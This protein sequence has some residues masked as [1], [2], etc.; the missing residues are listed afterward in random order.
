MWKGIGAILILLGVA[1]CLHRWYLQQKEKQER[2]EELIQ[3]V[4]KSIHVMETEKMK[5]IDWFL[6]Y[7]NKRDFLLNETLSEIAKR[8]QTNTYASGH[9]VWEDVFFEKWQKLGFEEDVLQCLIQLGSGFFGKSR[10]E[11]IGI[12]QRG[13]KELEALQKK[14]KEKDAQER[15]VW[16]PVGMLGGVMII[17]L[18]I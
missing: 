8:L 6:K 2:L 13:L 16:V 18:F 9:A 10:V 12:L 15:K 4:H 11:N 17:I 1:G 7:K 3:F 14:N 5:A